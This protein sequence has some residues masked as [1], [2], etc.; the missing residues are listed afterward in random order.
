MSKLPESDST[1]VGWRWG[2][3]QLKL[4]AEMH[5][6]RRRGW[7]TPGNATHVL[8]TNRPACATETAEDMGTTMPVATPGSLSCQSPTAE[9]E[10]E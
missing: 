10:R 1:S 8:E 5:R 4:L 9:V 6:L 7:A 3:G 2:A